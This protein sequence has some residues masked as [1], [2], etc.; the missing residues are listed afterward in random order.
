MPVLGQVHR[1][2]ARNLNLGGIRVVQ[3]TGF[4][5]DLVVGSQRSPLRSDDQGLGWCWCWCWCRIRC[6]GNG[7]G[8][9]FGR[10]AARQQ[11]DPHQCCKS[12]CPV[13]CGHDA[14]PRV[15]PISVH[16]RASLSPLAARLPAVR[17][18][19]RT[20]TAERHVDRSV[21]RNPPGF[22]GSAHLHRGPFGSADDSAERLR[23]WG[24]PAERDQ[25]RRTGLASDERKGLKAV[26]VARPSR[27]ATSPGRRPGMGGAGPRQRSSSP[28]FS[29]SSRAISRTRLRAS[30]AERKMSPIPATFGFST[31][32]GLSS[33]AN[34]P[35][36]GHL[37]I[38]WSD[39]IPPKTPTSRMPSLL[40]S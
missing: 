37:R 9:G 12:D 5:R 11:N 26:I 15:E 24:R 40:P 14:L 13:A 2:L 32:I 17:A 35:A 33:T 16:E 7:A 3:M 8:A 1:R 19:P 23:R 21:T 29:F 18:R 36:L 39:Y 22:S 25:G 34:Y 31:P 27:R 10:R 30:R 38:V 4:R 28:L 6:R 20:G